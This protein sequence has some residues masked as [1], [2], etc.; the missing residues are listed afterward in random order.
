MFTTHYSRA[1]CKHCND[2]T[3]F[4]NA[5]E[6]DDYF[7][8]DCNNVFETYLLS[9]VPDDKI[10][11]Q[12]ERYIESKRKDWDETFKMLQPGYS[13]MRMAIDMFSPPKSKIVIIEADAGQKAIDKQKREERER[14]YQKKREERE[15]Q[16]KEYEAYSQL[17]RN[18]KCIC[19]SGLKYKKCCLHK[20]QNMSF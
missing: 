16:R 19:G 8:K 2:W 3:L 4:E 11:E 17:G 14:A 5:K 7:C 6:S 1:W 12:R 9:D 15:K 18:D 10:I 13:E 20:F